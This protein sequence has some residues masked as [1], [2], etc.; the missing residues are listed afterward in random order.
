MLKNTFSKNITKGSLSNYKIQPVILSGGKGTRLWPLSREDFPKQYLKLNEKSEFSLLQNTFLRIRG[1]K[2]LESPLIICNEGQRFIVAE[3]MRELNIKPK[4]IILE[5]SGKNTAPAITLS[6]LLSYREEK[7]HILL[8]LSSDHLIENTKKFLDVINE[9]IP[10]ANEGRLVT[11]GIVPKSAETGYGYIE[12]YDQLTKKCLASKI[13]SFI[14]KPEKEIAENLIKDKHYL[15]NSGIFLFKSS[16]ILKEL[17][18]FQPE[19]VELCK[20]YDR[21]VATFQQTRDILNLKNLNMSVPK[22]N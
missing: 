2:R 1:L 11:F 6:A 3:Q 8:V 4:S 7:D 12:S 5:P 19:I 21:P 10:Y 16:T 15:W 18:R 22:I 20:K 17:R 13:K 9:A 14:E